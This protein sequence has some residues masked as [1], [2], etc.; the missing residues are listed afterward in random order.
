MRRIAFLLAAWIGAG[1]T[2]SGYYHF[3]HYASRTAPFTPIVERF[4]LSVLP[5]KTVSYYI[6][7]AGPTQLAPN[8]S[9]IALYGH[10]RAA[11]R[12]WNDVESS[13][14]RL[15]FGGLSPAALVQNEPGI[16]VVFDEIPPGLVALGGPTVVAEVSGGFVPIVR[17]VVK[18][19][20]DLTERPSYRDNFFQSAVHEFGHA[21]G[22]QHVL[23]GSVMS[24]E[25]TRGTSKAR[26][27]GADDIAGISLL[28]PTAAF[29]SSTASIAGRVTLS[30]QSVNMA[31]I[32]AIAPNGPA[33][34]ALSNPDG[35]YRIEGIPPGSYV[36]YVHPL[37]PALT[38]ETTPAN[39][40]L[41]VDATGRPFEPSRNFD[42][43][44]YPGTRD[45][46]LASTL[47]VASGQSLDGIN[48]SVQS[49]SPPSM[50]SVQTYSYPANYGVKPAFVDFT[51]QRNY[52]V[53]AGAGLVSNGVPTQGLALSVLGG[54]LLVP[55]GGIK[56][57][58]SDFIQIDFVP[59]AP[60]GE[61]QR[62]LVFSRGNEIY[63]LPNGLH[64]AVRQPPSITAVAPSA[65]GG[66]RTALVAGVNLGA[67]TRFWFDGQPA[68][69]LDAS[70]GIIT[71]QP[72]T[73]P[74]GHRATVVA[75]SNDG[76]TSMFVQAQNPPSYLYEGVEPAAFAFNPSTFAAGTETVVEIVGANTGFV[77]GQT[78]IGFGSS[79]IAV[80][81][82]WV[83]S[84]TRI[85]ANV[86]VSPS[87]APGV[88]SVSVTT[89][90]RI[91]T[92]TGGVQ[93]QPA[94]GRPLRLA[95]APPASLS[96]EFAT[97][98][99]GSWS[100]GA[101]VTLIV[102]NLTEAQAA[103]G[104]VLTI[105]GSRVP[106]LSAAAGQVT[107][108]VPFLSPG[109]VIVRLQSGTESA[110]LVVPIEIPVTIVSVISGNLPVDSFRPARAAGES[111]TVV[112][113][114]FGDL[115]TTISASRARVS[116]DGTEYPAS[117]VVQVPGD[118][119]LHLIQ[120]QL[121]PTAAGTHTLIVTM[122]GRSSQ[123]FQLSVR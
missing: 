114:G 68:T 51:S 7:E 58:T 87:A 60:L 10:I 26:P 110:A 28:Y 100:S 32:V 101:I 6:S 98:S 86:A 112:A 52:I 106:L 92:Q 45:W 65:T 15:R 69:V 116:V 96:T 63:V 107:F 70:N 76:Q 24:T 80:R 93:I 8:D 79:D 48:F 71:L 19:N 18:F 97:T 88:T 40:V 109:P 46:Q 74:A 81:R 4:D 44:F 94:T 13:D 37:P 2:A 105:N 66:I 89:G 50:H 85:L 61:G 43:Q 122:D 103:A 118:A 53:A 78:S 99:T 117:Q 108:T 119:P 121:G 59:Q 16:D 12:V 84:P 31:S 54:S 41:P 83:I 38:G 95:V 21:M 27:L 9:P 104:P 55:P 14:I 90:L 42:T 47:T 82:M 11:A 30:G 1:A 56:A 62:H 115:G 64:A 5:N 25:I 33:I 113:N 72:P 102:Q 20:R 35:T 34:S 120:F 75:L 111:L 23:T 17:S 73:A 91:T 123:P 67:D 49:A 3:V 39:I 29:R 57:F 36:L 77:E 22:L